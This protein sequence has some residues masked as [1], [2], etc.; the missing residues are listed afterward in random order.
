MPGSGEQTERFAETVDA[1]TR[2]GALRIAM[3]HARRAILTD[4][5]GWTAWRT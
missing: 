5:L 2:R 4:R 1:W 3:R